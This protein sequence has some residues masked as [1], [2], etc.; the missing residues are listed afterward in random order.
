MRLHIFLFSGSREDSAMLSHSAACRINS[1]AG[2]ITRSP[3]KHGLLMQT[4]KRLKGFYGTASV[5]GGVSHENI[6]CNSCIGDAAE[7]VCSRSIRHS[8]GLL[9]FLRT[10]PAIC[11]VSSLLRLLRPL[12]LPLTV[13]VQR[14]RPSRPL[15][16]LGS[17]SP[18]ARSAAARSHPGRILGSGITLPCTARVIATH[19][20]CTSG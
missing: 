10:G 18:R 17:G 15:R 5:G 4:R 14:V 12:R 7:F 11:R 3:L 1:S 2:T 6:P 16:W 19:M 20:T 13:P 9:P 8:A